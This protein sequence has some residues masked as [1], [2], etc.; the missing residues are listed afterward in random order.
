MVARRRHAPV[1]RSPDDAPIAGLAEL[2]LLDFIPRCSPELQSPYPLRPLTDLL[3]QAPHGNLRVLSSPP[4]RHTKTTTLC[5]FITWALVRDPTLKIFF[6]SHSAKFS[7][8]WSRYARRLAEACGVRLSADFNTI[9]EWTTEAGGGAYWASCDQEVIGRG[10]DVVIVDDPIGAEDVWDVRKRDEVDETISFVTTRL[11]V[12]GS[13]I[14]NMSRMSDDDPIGRRLQGRA[15]EWQE[16]ALPAIIDE[17][18]PNERALWEDLRPLEHLHA[19]RAELCEQGD[20]WAWESQYQG[21]PPADQSG[22]F[23]GT[24]PFVGAVP[25]GARIVIGIDAAYSRGRRSDFFAAVVVAEVEG[26]ACVIHVVKH[27]RGTT[28]IIETCF[29]LKTIYPTAR[30]ASY[31]AGPEKGVYDTLFLLG[32]E[33]EQMPA[34]WNKG[35]RA[36]RCAHAWENGRVLVRPKEPW[37]RDFIAECHAFSGYEDPHDDQVDALVSAYDALEAGR[38]VPG[39]STFLFGRAVM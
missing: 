35:V 25:D 12:G 7:Q 30:L 24:H 39:F 29:Q 28:G 21:R 8:K 10:A 6:L 2:S 34:R 11:N 14:L 37:S 4:V 13:V 22:V 33:I 20:R 31:I 1:D 23:V 38:P 19:V 27:Q 3:E 17:N 15:R 32:L 9:E 36:K 26:L 5:H 16:I 18:G